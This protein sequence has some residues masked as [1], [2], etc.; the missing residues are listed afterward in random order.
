M[1]IDCHLFP[2]LFLLI[3]IMAHDVFH[4]ND[5]T[6]EMWTGICFCFHFQSR[7]KQIICFTCLN[8]SHMFR[9]NSMFS[10][11]LVYLFIVH[12]NYTLIHVKIIRFPFQFDF[13]TRTFAVSFTFF[14]FLLIIRRSSSIRSLDYQRLIKNKENQNMGKPHTLSFLWICKWGQVVVLLNF[15]FGVWFFTIF[16]RQIAKT[17]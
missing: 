5:S 7:I 11:D 3:A 1:T 16:I 13:F 10:S 17:K 2:A 14:P 15:P 8:K 9:T 4:L 12:V 6:I